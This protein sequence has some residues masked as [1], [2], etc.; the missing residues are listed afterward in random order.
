MSIKAMSHVWEHSNQKGSRLLMLLAIADFADD[1][2]VAYPGIERLA[3]KTRMSE[4]NAQMT[5]RA[6]EQAGELTIQ[7]GKGIETGH[8][9][10]N[11]YNLK[12]YQGSIGYQ[13][14][15]V[16]FTSYDYGVKPTSPQEVKPISPLG[17]KPT[18]PKPS[19][20]PSVEPS[21]KK[22]DPAP[23]VADTP[24]TPEPTIIEENTPALTE[25][26][27]KILAFPSATETIEDTPPRAELHQVVEQTLDMKSAA[28]GLIEKYVNFFTG[29]TP[30]YSKGKGKPR[31]NGEWFE[32]QINPAM[33]IDEI[34]AFGRWYRAGHSGGD[35]PS[36]C[37]TLNKQ[38]AK[39]RAAKNHDRY[40]D[41]FHRDR[42][43]VVIVD[44]SALPKAAG[45]EG[46]AIPISA[47]KKV[48][49]ERLMSELLAKMNGN[50]VKRGSTNGR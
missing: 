4:R 3:K 17:V 25:G 27:G 35:F 31:H 41:R 28:Y 7:A 45:A 30:E 15:A 19:V 20:E 26:S 33:S 8:G 43:S 9:C 37:I 18:S 38:V 47:D 34:G 21:E 42:T 23:I 22:S 49:A 11:R 2:G 6:L 16:N 5:L 44:D 29:Q 46:D 39:F 50:G 13:R 12:Q 40:V 10:T 32:Y 36:T 24:P 48:E 14:E 1:H